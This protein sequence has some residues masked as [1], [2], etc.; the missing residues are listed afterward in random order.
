MKKDQKS[1]NADSGGED[2]SEADWKGMME[3]KTT[4]LLSPKERVCALLEAPPKLNAALK[5][6]RSRPSILENG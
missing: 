5:Q 6:L 4:I 2:I 1:T 3:H